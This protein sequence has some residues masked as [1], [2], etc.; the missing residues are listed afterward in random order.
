MKIFLDRNN[1][2]KSRDADNTLAIE[3]N[4]SKRLL[5]PLP[6]E[7]S[8]SELDIYNSERAS[9]TTIRLTVDVNTI[10]TNVLHNNVTEIVKNEGSDNVRVYNYSGI[11][12]DET[13]L[14][15][16][17]KGL[18]F[19]TQNSNFKSYRNNYP[20]DDW[21]NYYHT[22]EAIRDTQISS[23]KLGYKYHCGVDIFN[24]HL[25]RSRTFKAIC[26]FT[27][28]TML[29][30]FNTIGDRLR[31]ADG[32]QVKMYND[33]VGS[34]DN[35]PSVTAHVYLDEEIMSFPESI[36]ENL[37]EDNGWFGF[38][39]VA[40][41]PMYSGSTQ[42]DFS[43]VINSRKGYDF[44]DMY[45]ERDLFSFT[46][47]FNHYRKRIEK[48]WNYCLTYPSSSTTNV[49]FI[50]EETKSLKVFLF[51]DEIINKN[52]TSGI[53][54]ITYSKHGLKTNDMINVY[55]G[56]DIALYNVKVI[57]VDD[58]YTFY[59]MS[60]GVKLCKEWGIIDSY[61]GEYV[62]SLGFIYRFT[63]KSKK[64]VKRIGTSSSTITYNGKKYSFDDLYGGT[65]YTLDRKKFNVD[66]TAQDISFKKTI[67]G[68]ECDYHVRIFSKLPNWRF[69]DTLPTEY[70]M[71]KEGSD[72][73]SKY[74][75]KENEFETN[76]G[77]LGFARNIYN[78]E[79]TEIVF[80]DD[81]N[82]DGLKDNLGRPLTEIYFTI[83]KNNAGYREWYGKGTD[84]N[85]NSENV[86]YSHCFGKNTC[87]FKLCKECVIDESLINSITIH[88]SE[89]PNS[90][91][92]ITQINNRG[93]K[94]Y[95]DDD[96]IEFNQYKDYCGDINFYGDLCCYSKKMCLEETIQFV[97]FRFNTVQREM[98]SIYESFQ[99]HYFDRFCWDEIERD[100]FDGE[101][102]NNFKLEAIKTD[103]NNDKDKIV[104]YVEV[105]NAQKK[106]GYC[107]VP[108]YKIQ[109]RNFSNNLQTAYPIFKSINKI[110]NKSGNTYSFYMVNRHSLSV[111]NTFE[112]FNKTEKV[113]YSCKV[114]NVIGLKIFEAT[115]ELNKSDL[116][117]D[118]DVYDVTEGDKSY[119][120]S[121]T[122]T[123]KS[124]Y[125]LFIRYDEE[126][127][128]YATFI[129]DGSCR[130][131][132]RDIEYNGQQSTTMS[133]EEYPFSNNA[134][135][136]EKKI[137]LFVGRQ[138]KDKV[139]DIGA[140]YFHGDNKPK[141]IIND[142]DTYYNEDDTVC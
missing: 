18:C 76:I 4:G 95:L 23:D 123:N 130:F 3:L 27:A 16:A 104:N 6:I 19:M 24:N 91:L 101:L 25:L 70:E 110:V 82:F 86:E 37:S 78:D 89:S 111:G 141:E 12:S 73:I 17:K 69:A 136:I 72:L 50:R 36:R 39:N 142:L 96:E 45:P 30:E 94:N 103:S 117:E 65:L 33:K 137:N 32:T 120:N 42:Y 116:P 26:P 92:S 28:T 77:K 47:K 1:S 128:K 122:V 134:F 5:P 75:T 127:P 48:N 59:V 112:M 13:A 31:N 121:I 29:P 10:A 115:V 58:D 56:D 100:D 133:G 139:S 71:Y 54:F 135:Y 22:F 60:N 38:Y 9:C 124:N 49:Q 51:D 53:K 97:D 132:W 57:S 99:N 83:I 43:K 113:R 107:Y 40:K 61:G 21:V 85:P 129:K 84:I 67:D 98:T 41:F 44:I 114:T 63:D 46:P 93:D 35:K 68:V 2:K 87:A 8:V 109:L 20:V 102:T 88:N 118:I 7:E 108:H 34:T 119:L 11:T 55:K 79:V 66:L 64:A 131:F 106:E 81:I 52:G 14:I 15:H 62:D 126:I 74:Q 138:D 80:A 140:L 125:R 90:G 105:N